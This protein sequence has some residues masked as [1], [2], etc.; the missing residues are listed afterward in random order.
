[1]AALRAE[2][3][4]RVSLL[5]GGRSSPPRGNP[6]FREFVETEFLNWSQAQNKRNTHK[7]YCVSSKPLTGFL[8]RMRLDE[9][10]TND[11]ELFKLKRLRQCSPGQ[12][13]LGRASLHA[14]YA[15]RNGYLTESPFKVKFLEEGPGNM[16][17]VS[18]E[19]EAVYRNTLTR[20]S[21]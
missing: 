9:I 7:R 8:G 2:A 1:M 16:R 18:H 19:E 12:P 20:R 3:D 10:T 11:I 17:I 15:V 13:R 21:H 6:I 5:N 14:H 4:K